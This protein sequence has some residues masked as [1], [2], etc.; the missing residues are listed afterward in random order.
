MLDQLDQVFVHLRNAGRDES[1]DKISR[2]HLLEVIELRAGR[3]LSQ[4]QV[5]SYYQSK[6]AELVKYRQCNSYT[7]SLHHLLKQIYFQEATF[8]PDTPSTGGQLVPTSVQSENSP[9]ASPL[10]LL[11]PGEV[12]KYTGKFDNTNNLVTTAQAKSF[13]KDEVVIRNADSGKGTRD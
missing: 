4:D 11:Q 6:L 2:L 7:P 8:G 12:V 10:P 3:W 1:L 9:P 5:C 13:I